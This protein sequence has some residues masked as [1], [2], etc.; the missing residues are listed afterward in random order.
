MATRLPIGTGLRTSA[1]AC[2]SCAM[3]LMLAGCANLAN[4]LL[5]M[6][7]QQIGQ[8]A[9]NARH[10]VSPIS[11]EEEQQIGQESA[12]VLLG[13]SRPVNN[14]A[15]QEYVNRV[16]LWIALHSDRPDLQWHFAVLDDTDIDAYAAPGGYVFVTKGLLLRLHSE[17]ELAGVLGHEITHV[18]R[19]HHLNEIRR[20]SRLALVGTAAQVELQ[21]N[22]YST[23]ALSQIAAGAKLVYSRGLDKDDEFQAD[24][25]GVVLAARSGYDPFG[26][27]AVL[28]MLESIDPKS[29]S[30]EL[31]LKTHPTPQAR[32]AA[33]SAAMQAGD[34]QKYGNQVEGA[35]RFANQMREFVG[36]IKN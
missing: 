19:K 11:L 31:L 1:L 25:E 35:E 36:T 22:G 20:E 15:L 18:V 23:Q 10:A 16:G 28:Q 7:P 34:M 32:I 5:Q 21:Q 12:A 30:V 33:L 13:A 17:A 3:V 9:Q 27:L 14:P 4:G 24:R 8:L 2:I 26:L 6:S 29:G